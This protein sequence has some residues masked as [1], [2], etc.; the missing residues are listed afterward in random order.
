MTVFSMFETPVDRL[1]RLILEGKRRI[2]EE[3]IA[4]WCPV[5]HHWMVYPLPDVVTEAWWDEHSD[6]MVADHARCSDMR[7]YMSRVWMQERR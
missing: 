7:P 1:D 4:Y 6:A 5:G 2:V 3:G